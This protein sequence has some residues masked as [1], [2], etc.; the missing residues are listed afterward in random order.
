MK[1]S[2]MMTRTERVTRNYWGWYWYIYGTNGKKLLQS[3]NYYKNRTQCRNVAKKYAKIMK[4]SYK[5][6]KPKENTK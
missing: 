1:Y 5:E 2:V 3:P 4:M 6:I